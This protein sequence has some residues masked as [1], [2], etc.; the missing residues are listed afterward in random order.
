MVH[1]SETEGQLG[2]SFALISDI[3]RLFSII[4]GRRKRQLAALLVLQLLGA[5]SEVVSLGALV[6]FLAVLSDA[7]A[8]FQHPQMQPVV[9]LLGIDD[10]LELIAVLSAGFAAAFAFANGM[11][12]FTLWVQVRLAA[13]IGSDLS[14]QLYRRTLHQEFEYFARSHSGSLISTVTNDFNAA[15]AVVSSALMIVTQGLVIVAIGSA[16]VAYD[17]VLAVTLIC[18]TGIAY[19]IVTRVNQRK[20]VRIGRIRSDMYA[21]IIR[22]L[23]EGFGGIRDVLLGRKQQTFLSRYGVKERAFRRAAA[24]SQYLRSAPRYVLETIGVVIL[25]S[26]ASY[27]ALSSGNVFGILPVIGAI[28]MAASRLLPAMQQVYA[29]YAALQA[30]HVSLRRTLAAFN[31]PLDPATIC[32]VATISSPRS[33]VALEDV[34]FRYRAADHDADRQDWI[35]HGVSLHIPVNKTVALVGATGS[36]K[37]TIADLLLGLLRPARGQVTLDGVALDNSS[38]SAWRHMAA[39]VPQSIFLSDATVSENIAFGVAAEEIDQD[40]VRYAAHLARVDE[41]V[42]NRPRGYAEIIGEN[43]IRLSGGQRQRIGIARAI[44]RSAALVVFDEATSAL[45]NATEWSVMRAIENLKG[46]TTIVLIAHR[47]S[48]VRNA[49]LICEISDGRVVAEGTFDELLR[50][51]ESFR[52]LVLPGA[53][54]EDG[55]QDDA[56]IQ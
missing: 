34:W 16:L 8:Y 50:K 39:S 40:R 41:F 20:L 45:D 53:R 51:S 17:A 44:Y 31:M 1:M 54:T 28:A 23:Q 11:R 33:T 35:L 27:M 52:R 24:D 25:T 49:D 18:I 30:V 15:I 47:L 26:V 37:S 56:L 21:A 43:G 42:E 48:T 12:L 9:R 32:P 46:Q 2:S 29:A 19:G 4:S 36:G 7:D 10:R 55:I 13:A 5:M 3:R 6:P 22:V 14:A 38:L